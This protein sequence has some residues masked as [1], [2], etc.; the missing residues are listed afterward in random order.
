LILASSGFSSAAL[1]TASLNSID[2][3]PRRRLGLGMR[4]TLDGDRGSRAIV[5]W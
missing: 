4:D 2:H 1:T 3:R 5:G